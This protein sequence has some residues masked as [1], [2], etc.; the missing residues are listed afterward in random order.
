MPK[1]KKKPSGPAGRNVGKKGPTITDD[2][3]SDDAPAGGGFRPA[4]RH[5]DD[6]DDFEDE[7]AGRK[8]VQKEPSG[9]A[10][11]KRK[12]HLPRKEDSDDELKVP[13]RKPLK[14]GP[15]KRS[16]DSDDDF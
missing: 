4:K 3:D 7:A 11:G 10:G 12:A 5:G 8:K 1:L 13:V 16:H 6:S 9:S 15:A 2:D 14:K